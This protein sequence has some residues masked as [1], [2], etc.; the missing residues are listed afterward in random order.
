M[1]LV[2]NNCG[3]VLNGLVYKKGANYIG[4]NCCVSI[5]NI[6]THS[7]SPMRIDIQKATVEFLTSY[8]ELAALQSTVSILPPI[9]SGVKRER[10]YYTVRNGQKY[11]LL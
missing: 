7:Y 4:Y 9:C 2:C 8:Q 11:K 1:L 10:A 5:R 3:D 6:Q